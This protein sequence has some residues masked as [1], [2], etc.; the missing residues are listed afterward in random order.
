M[1]HGTFAGAMALAVCLSA[2]GGGGGGSSF[3]MPETMP[4]AMPTL[5]EVPELP[6][7]T[8]SFQTTEAPS[9]EDVVKYLRW[10]AGNIPFKNGD[11]T[12][13]HDPGLVRFSS[14]PIVLLDSRITKHERAA[15]YHAVSVI[16]NS[17]PFDQHI[18]IEENFVTD[19]RTVS[20]EDVPHNS[21]LI[22]WHR[23]GGAASYA[24]SSY[25][26]VYD[27]GQNRWEKR[28]LN[29]GRI[30]MFHEPDNGQVLLHELLHALG[31]HAHP[32]S[33]EFP[34][35]QLSDYPNAQIEPLSRLDEVEA[36]AVQTLYTKLGPFT[37]P[38]E[39]SA[40]SLGQWDR[41]TTVFSG[42]IALD[43][44]E[45]VEFGVTTHNDL[46]RPWT[47]NDLFNGHAAVPL[48]DN[49]E[50]KGT[51]TWDG[52]LVGVTPTQAYVQGDTSIDVNMNTLT[53]TASFTG[54]EF[55]DG[56]KTGMQW[57]TGELEYG[58][59][60]NGMLLRSTGGDAGTV[61]GL[62]YGYEHNTVGG[63]LERAD[64]TGAFGAV[65][66]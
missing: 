57:N 54:L 25:N 27:E 47:R 46:S 42:Q 14:I 40:G 16:N 1:K 6:A 53:G 51:V 32:S 15:A 63:T 48:L 31:L 2:C 3:S 62:F 13:T 65:R 44:N 39:L 24:D 49:P 11:T 19:A 18:R 30:R 59:T 34:T 20:L 4:D 7:V 66:W 50:L 9:A 35:S 60:V 5:P 37:E 55:W 58:I 12:T 43:T 36:S 26:F 56:A 17:L 33:D 52:G 28:G 29:A 8:T 38:E 45:V 21:I 61:N 23:E 41:Q 22:A 10:H 64:L